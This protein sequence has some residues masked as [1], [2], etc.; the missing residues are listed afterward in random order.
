MPDES[1]IDLQDLID[2]PH[3]DLHVEL[4]AW[5]DLK[6]PSNRAN[7]AR[8][9]A[10]LCNHGGGI[11]IF[12][13]NDDGSICT[14]HAADLSQYDHNVFAGVIDRY[15]NPTFQCRVVQ[16]ARTQG[17]S[18]FPIIRVPPHGSTP[19]FA[20]ADGPKIDGR[21][22]GIRA[23]AI[24]VRVP[25]PK[26]VAI[27]R[28]EFF[29]PLV[30]RC[31]INERESL[32]GSIGKLLG[33]TTPA[34]APTDLSL[35]DWADAA[36]KRFLVVANE[37]QYPWPVSIADNHYQLSFRILGLEKAY[38]DLNTLQ[39][40]M[41]RAHTATRN[42]VSTGWSM[43]YQ[44]TRPEIAPYVIVD[45]TGG[46]NVDAFETNLLANS[47]DGVGLPDFWH[48][49]ANGRATLIRCYREDRAVFQGRQPGTWLAPRLLIREITELITYAKE[50]SKA[51]VGANSV[52]FRCSW[53]GL[54]NRHIADF[55]SAVEWD[56]RVSRVSTRTSSGQWAAE[57]IIADIAP[58]VTSLAN[59]AL[60]L[61]NG[62]ELSP[63]FVRKEMPRFLT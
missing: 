14:P 46:R 2:N 59:P 32:L 25:G 57:E 3:E 60:R 20:K 40:E 12:G 41:Q 6:E 43:F 38:L 36:H 9:L 37:S 23:G 51:F 53:W 47:R 52:E 7:V 49:T 42:I 19:V 34:T 22:T 48:V 21:V 35:S 28:P 54:K 62:L 50:L 39:Q 13:F 44:F 61:F 56:E 8:H 63:D 10:A 18:V 58:I 30:H 17:G 11:L 1:P 33:T 15:L 24:Y 26:S 45:D 55:E 27:D 31:V 16:L 29:R 5:M 4:K